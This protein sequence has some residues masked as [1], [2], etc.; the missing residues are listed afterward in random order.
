MK[1]LL[2]ASAA[3]SVVLLAACGGAEE[4]TAPQDAASTTTTPVET[5]AEAAA[6]TGSLAWAV[7]GDWR[8]AEEKA[9]DDW[10]NPVETLQF[11]GVESDDTVVEIWPGG[12]W[13]TQILGPYLKAGGGN[14][15][16]AG[17]D[18]A[19][20]EFAANAVARYNET[21]VGNPGAYGDITVSVL[22]ADSG[23]IAPEG[24][25]DVILTF[26]NVHNWMSGGFADKVF[27]DSYAALKPGGILGVVEHRL[28]S[29][30]AQD[31]AA[32]S[33]YVHED[34]VISLAIEA[35]FELVEK[36]EINANP[37]D[38]ADHPFGVWTLPPVSRSADRDGNAPE[39]FDPADYAAIGESDR[40]T[41]KFRKPLPED[42]AVPASPQE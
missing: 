13:Y 24:T 17:F 5:Q 41:L 23:P 37:A 36:S 33:G 42:A 26:R 8:T 31:P 14:L 15:I 19:R 28:P 25:V 7:A 4:A 40:M 38:T 1:N 12:G 30:M 10:R 6:A 9:R 18:P 35:G 16:S 32:E 2:M 27:A 20:S 3:A 11:F 22:S 34:Y 29:A 39:G 21:Y